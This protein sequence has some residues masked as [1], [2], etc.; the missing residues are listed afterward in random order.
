MAKVNYIIKG[1]ELQY[2]YTSKYTEGTKEAEELVF[3]G[4]H[5]AFL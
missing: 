2:F 4:G 3:G 5:L 1:L